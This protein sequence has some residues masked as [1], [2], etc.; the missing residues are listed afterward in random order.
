MSR[1][2]I[3]TVTGIITGHCFLRKRLH[4]MGLH[5][6]EPIYRLCNEEEE[7]ADRILFEWVAL[8]NWRR[9]FLEDINHLELYSEFSVIQ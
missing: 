6:E 7:A 1:N 5:T 9:S 3:R 8:E 2:L 4:N